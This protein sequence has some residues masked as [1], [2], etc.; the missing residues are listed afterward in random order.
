MSNRN[1]GL[2]LRE[3]VR[4]ELLTPQQAINTLRE[5]DPKNAN[6]RENAT[7]RWLLRKGAR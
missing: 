4:Q 6:A 5:V 7:Y 3:R 1:V 2:K